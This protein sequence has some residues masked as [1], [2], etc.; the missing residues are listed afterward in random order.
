MSSSAPADPSI[1]SCRHGQHNS[2]ILR[3]HQ[4][5]PQRGLGHLL[6]LPI[7]QS[8]HPPPNRS[9][10]AQPV[11]AWHP[12]P[13][14]RHLCLRSTHFASWW[15]PPPNQSAARPTL[16]SPPRPSCQLAQP[17]GVGHCQR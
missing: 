17:A 15:T 3:P 16:L 7:A 13:A 12:A 9:A 6:P 1:N 11:L 14:H 2:L 8:R 10:A 4:Q 5:A